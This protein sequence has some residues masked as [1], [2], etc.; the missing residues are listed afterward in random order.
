MENRIKKDNP[1]NIKDYLNSNIG[2]FYNFYLIP[3]IF[4]IRMLILISI[5]GGDIIHFYHKLNWTKF[6]SSLNF[7]NLGVLVNLAPPLRKEFYEEDFEKKFTNK[8]I[9]EINMKNIFTKRKIKN[10]IN[11][12]IDDYKSSIEVNIYNYKNRIKNFSNFSENPN[13]YGDKYYKSFLQLLN[14]YSN[15]FSEDIEISIYDNLKEENNLSEN[16]FLTILDMVNDY[17]KDE[18]SKKGFLALLKQSFLLGKLRTNIV[19]ILYYIFYIFN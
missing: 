13:N 16:N 19:S 3:K 1:N 7:K 2:K 12:N 10:I 8:N 9:E 14:N 6:F 4:F 11:S 15:D 5:E 18:E 17:I